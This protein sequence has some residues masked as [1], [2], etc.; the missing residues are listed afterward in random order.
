MDDEGNRPWAME[1]AQIAEVGRGS[2]QLLFRAGML[3]GDLLT[4]CWARSRNLLPSR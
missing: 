1:A 3:P 2:R 4:G